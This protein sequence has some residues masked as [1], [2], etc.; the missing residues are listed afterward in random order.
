MGVDMSSA[1]DTI[2]RD[3]ILNVLTEVG[4]SEDD[5]RLVRTLLCNTKLSIRVN[6][7]V[8]E[9]FNSIIGAFQGDCL[10]GNLFTVVLAA[11]LHHLRA[12]LSVRATTP[13]LVTHPIPNPPI[14][15]SLMPLESE[16]ADD[17][18]FLNENRDALLQI[19]P[20]CTTVFNEWNLFINNT[21]TE[22]THVYLAPPKPLKRNKVD[23][24]QTYRGSEEWRT[25]KILGSLLDTSEDIQARCTK[26]L[27]AFNIFENIWLKKTKICLK[28]KLQIY[29]AQ[30][31]SIL[32]YN[33]SS[34]AAPQTTLEKLD[35]THR[36]HLR[37]ILNIRWP[38]VISNKCLYERCKTEPLSSRVAIARWRLFGHILRG[39]K[40]S[41]A[42]LAILF[43]IEKNR[44]SVCKPRLGRPITNLLDVLKNDLYVRGLKNYNLIEM[45]DLY[46][47]EALAYNRS[48]WKKLEKV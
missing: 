29:E 38:G 16:Y 18:D 9:I 42:Y 45:N 21:K 37:R 40:D 15:D 33:C 13:H 24:T 30:V 35:I 4:C 6:N 26:G 11:A 8:S 23:H 10:S 34:W 7:S 3:T 22:H 48:E 12:V 44:L 41:P 14:S 36:K 31:V 27:I 19:L 20:I 47:I 17:V 2:K 43:G 1:F 28:R 5:V 32:L 46:E 25:H 39:D